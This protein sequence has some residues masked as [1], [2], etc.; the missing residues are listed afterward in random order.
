MCWPVSLLYSLWGDRVKHEAWTI[1]QMQA[2]MALL[3]HADPR[4][5]VTPV[6]VSAFTNA[7]H[8]ATDTAVIDL[9]NPGLTRAQ[10]EDQRW[11][12][13]APVAAAAFE[14]L[15]LALEGRAARR[16]YAWP[17][18]L[19]LEGVP[20]EL[21]H[22]A[23]LDSHPHLFDDLIDAKTASAVLGMSQPHLRKLVAAGQLP[24]C[25][26]IRLGARGMY[27]FRMAQIEA[28]ARRRIAARLVGETSICAQ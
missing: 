21:A 10:L 15:G 18:I 17:L 19:A 22:R 4:N 26:V 23:C 2:Q 13:S 20:E 12:V 6:D 27:R 7:D 5:L 25:D 9:K 11:K 28:E 1:D 14:R 3:A 16:L 8:P 24:G